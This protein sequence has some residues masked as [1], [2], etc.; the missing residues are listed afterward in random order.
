M[1][2]EQFERE[3]LYQATLAV[4]Q[5]MRRK[6]LITEDELAII[7]TKMREKYRPL[8]GNLLSPNALIS[9]PE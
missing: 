2:K 1:S 7:D 5:T 8:L 3:R 6:R 4:A 9:V